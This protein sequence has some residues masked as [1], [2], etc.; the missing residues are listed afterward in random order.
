MEG[1]DFVFLLI[2]AFLNHFKKFVW[3]HVH[4]VI[5][6]TPPSV[7][8]PSACIIGC[9]HG[10]LKMLHI[11][12]LL[13]SNAKQASDSIYIAAIILC[14]FQCTYSLAVDLWNEGILWLPPCIH[15]FYM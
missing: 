6:G 10:F 9:S 4:S 8:P 12:C 11:C 2:M 13:N 3:G 14:V 1:I 5:I 15:L 7:A